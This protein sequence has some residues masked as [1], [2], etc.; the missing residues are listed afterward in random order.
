MDDVSF[1]CT[2]AA[3]YLCIVDS[4]DRH[5][6][7]Q[8]MAKR[9]SIDS[10]RHRDGR[11]HKESRTSAAVAWIGRPR[12]GRIASIFFAE[13]ENSCNGTQISNLTFLLLAPVKAF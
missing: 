1:M 5:T 3:S 8:T 6:R 10:C 12:Y 11:W 9:L 7:W 4:D 2:H 13:L